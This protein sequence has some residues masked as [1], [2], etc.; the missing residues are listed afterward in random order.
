[1]LVMLLLLLSVSFLHKT[2]DLTE[3]SFSSSPA[4]RWPD[5]LCPA[6]L[7]LEDEGLSRI[8]QTVQAL[9]E[10]PLSG[11][12]RSSLQTPAPNFNSS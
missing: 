5:S 6:Q 12:R 2:C 3:A 7:I 1:M 9:L 8:T 11:S 10:L 4:L